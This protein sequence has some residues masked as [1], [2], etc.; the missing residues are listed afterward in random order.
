MV[1][2]VGS[3]VDDLGAAGAGGGGGVGECGGGGLGYK[4]V[5]LYYP[6]GGSRVDE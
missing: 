6:K 2:D 3:P 5:L 1:K 4:V